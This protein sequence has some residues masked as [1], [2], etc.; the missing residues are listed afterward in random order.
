MSLELAVKEMLYS[1]DVRTIHSENPGNYRGTDTSCQ[2]FH[3]F[4]VGF[5]YS[6]G[7][8]YTLFLLSVEV[9]QVL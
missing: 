3:H 2:F 5:S 4:S 8:S 9:Q 7:S 1:F 6:E